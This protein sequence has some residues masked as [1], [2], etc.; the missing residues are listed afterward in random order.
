MTDEQ[1]DLYEAAVENHI[2]CAQLAQREPTIPNQHAALKAKQ[3][4][5]RYKRG[6]FQ[7]AQY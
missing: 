6:N 4:L 7:Q 3:K 5:E 1:K 2:H